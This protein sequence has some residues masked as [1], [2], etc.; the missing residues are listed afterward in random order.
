MI[1]QRNHNQK[2]AARITIPVG[3][4]GNQWMCQVVNRCHCLSEESVRIKLR[5]NLATVFQDAT[6]QL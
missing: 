2:P 5:H 4:D 1:D 6:C 3:F